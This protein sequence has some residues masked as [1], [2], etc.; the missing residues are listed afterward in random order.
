ME[1]GGA[2]LVELFDNLV[3]EYEGLGL[4]V[5]RENGVEFKRR[6]N[7]STRKRERESKDII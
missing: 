4:R 1:W 7:E 3:R 5:E 6:K 2:P